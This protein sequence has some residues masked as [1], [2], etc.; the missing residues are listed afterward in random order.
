MLRPDRSIKRSYFTPA[1]MSTV[2]KKRRKIT[3]VG[4]VVEKLEP[5]EAR[6]VRFY[7]IN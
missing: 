1:G 3:S 2:K 5:V 6:M 4:E 7:K